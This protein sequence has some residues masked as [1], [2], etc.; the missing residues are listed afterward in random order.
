MRIDGNY[1]VEP[2]ILPGQSG[3]TPPKAA[4]APASGAQAVQSDP[5]LVARA[6]S[7]AAQAAA[8][9]EFNEQAVAEARALLEAGQL[10]SPE[11]IGRAAGAIADL[12]F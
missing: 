7:F 11:A 5:E 1:S 9:P 8:A 2:R 6:E 10:D 12:G 3:P 4:G